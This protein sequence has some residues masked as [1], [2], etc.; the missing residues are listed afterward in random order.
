MRNRQKKVE[1][2][3][4]D[5]D[6]AW[7]PGHSHARRIRQGANGAFDTVE[8]I[9]A[10]NDQ[11]ADAAVGNNDRAA[12]IA[13]QLVEHGSKRLIV[14]DDASIA[15]GERAGRIGFRTADNDVAVAV[16]ASSG[17]SLT[18]SAA[19]QRQVTST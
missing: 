7:N 4:Q 13:A 6:S 19:L 10:G 15:P 5:Y 2:L 16:T 17:S 1:G 14:E 9:V 3:S 8:T 18:C 12:V 11:A